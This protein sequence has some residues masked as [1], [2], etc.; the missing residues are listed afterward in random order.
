MSEAARRRLTQEGALAM[1]CCIVT[2][3]CDAIDTRCLSLCQV[4]C[5]LISF[6]LVVMRAGAVSNSESLGPL[7]WTWTVFNVNSGKDQ[8]RKPQ[9]S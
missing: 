8:K 5:D 1:S 6:P 2:H 7:K 4:I 9:S 3:V